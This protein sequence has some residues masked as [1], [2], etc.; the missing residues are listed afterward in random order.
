MRRLPIGYLIGR[1]AQLR[2]AIAAVR[3]GQAAIDRY[4]AV[5]GVALIGVGG[6]GK[7]ALAGRIEARLAGEGWLAAVHVGR[8]NPAAFI[9]AIVA[10]LA[11]PKCRDDGWL[12]DALAVL[13]SPEVP[14][15]AKVERVFALLEHARMLLVFD[16]FEQNLDVTGT[17]ISFSDPGFGEVFAGL[18]DAA[19]RGRLL[20]TSRYPIPDAGPFVLAVPVPPLSRAELRRL[21]LRLPALRD[22]DAPDRRALVEMI[23]GHP[24]LI[25]FVDALV[26]GGRGSMKDITIKLRA[27]SMGVIAPSGRR[28]LDQAIGEAILLGSRDILLDTLMQGLSSEERELLLQAAVSTVPKSI[29]DLAVARWGTTATPAEQAAAIAT[30]ER[31]LD[32]TLLSVADNDEIVMHPWIAESVSTH[33]DE[34][35]A[36]RNDRAAE[37]RLYRLQTGRGG[38]SD[39]VEICRHRGATARFKEVVAFA[40]QA[41]AALAQQLGQQ[42]VAAFLGEVVP[43]IP[44]DTDGFLPLA[45]RESQALLNTGSPSAA[46]R[47]TQ[48][49]LNTT[50]QRAEADPGNAQAQRDL[51]VCYERLGDL[52]LQLGDG[53]QA[54][55]FYRD[56]RA[57]AETVLTADDAWP[58][59]IREKLRSLEDDAK[60]T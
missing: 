37:M 55:R 51:S 17:T 30:A 27:L 11:A 6:I 22:L 32:L 57:I 42:S 33:Q 40:F 26:R 21:L 18:C 47:R 34:H 45:D 3:G 9:S 16:D 5:S 50:R 28:D 14:D 23:G 53:A 38:F 43:M 36:L 4:G 31:L 12:A 20:I 7:T 41:V 19:D 56:Q 24:R 1:R 35:L 8:W 15:T 58:Q 29:A 60:R 49:I 54:E 52:M 44:A 25:E 10:A 2:T 39:L 48:T 59:S 46:L 13:S